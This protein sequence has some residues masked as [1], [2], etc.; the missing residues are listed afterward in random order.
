MRIYVQHSEGGWQG[1]P[2]RAQEDVAAAGLLLHH[3]ARPPRE[4]RAAVHGPRLR[5]HV[6]RRGRGRRPGHQGRSVPPLPQQ[7]GPVRERLR[8]PSGAD[9]PRDREGHQPQQGPV[10]ACSDRPEGLPRGVPRAALPTHLPA[11]GTRRPRP[12]ALGR[13]GASRIPR[14]RSAH[15]RRPAQGPR[16][17]RGAQ[18]LVRDRVLWCDP[19]GVGIRRR[20]RGPRL[21]RSGGPGHD[22]RDPGRHATA[23]VNRPRDRSR[24]RDTSP[25]SSRPGPHPS[26]PSRARSCRARWS[27]ACRPRSRS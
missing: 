1:H 22:R 5:R 2:R 15:R 21:R 26:A 27:R 13:G 20:R 8:P 9:D 12:R 11:G 16:R 3:Q 23:A 24:C 10:G 4:R 7:A 17:W 6:A 19:L 14:H 18:R 25:V